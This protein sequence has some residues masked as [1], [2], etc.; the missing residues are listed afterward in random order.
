MKNKLKVL[1]LICAVSLISGCSTTKNEAND[2]IDEM[3]EKNW[4]RI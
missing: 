1:M 4:N 3:T 2:E